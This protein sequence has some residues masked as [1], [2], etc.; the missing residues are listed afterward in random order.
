MIADSDSDSDEKRVVALLFPDEGLFPNNPKLPLLIY[1]AAFLPFGGCGDPAAEVEAR[2]DGNGWPPAWRYG[3]YPFQHY[4]ACAHEALGVSRGSA[5]LQFGGVAGP[6]IDVEA[7][8]AVLLPAGTAH[9]L[10]SARAGFEVVG[11]YPPGQMPDMCYGEEDE[12]PRADEQIREVPI[13]ASDPVLG[14]E[15]GLVELWRS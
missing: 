7:G 10:I 3:V 5:R 14:L 11:A 1:V 15:G 4:H 12:R 13:P 6:V 9:K 2:F 8:D